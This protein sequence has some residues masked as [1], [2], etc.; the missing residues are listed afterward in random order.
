MRKG[1]GGAAAAIVVA[2]E[3]G[4]LHDKVAGAIGYP[5]HGYIGRLWAKING[6]HKHPAWIG[7]VD[8]FS[9]FIQFE[10]G[11][12]GPLGGI[13]VGPKNEV[14]VGSYGRAGGHGPF[15]EVGDVVRKVIAAEVN[16]GVGTVVQFEPIVVLPTSSTMPV[17]VSL[18]AI[19]SLMTSDWEKTSV[20]ANVV[21]SNRRGVR[22]FGHSKC[23]VMVRGMGKFTQYISKNGEKLGRV[24]DKVIG[25]VL[26]SASLNQRADGLRH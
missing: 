5:G 22:F 8:G 13:V 16:V 1:R 6:I 19:N 3:G 11:V 9:I 23:I 4:R 17:R 18:S 2:V 25:C 24:I 10:R 15:L 21:R 14:S 7:Q 26:I 12:E 20:A